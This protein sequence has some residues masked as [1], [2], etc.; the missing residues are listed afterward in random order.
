MRDMPPPRVRPLLD[1]ERALL[2]HM[3]NV[4]VPDVATLW[5]QAEVASAAADPPLAWNVYL[6]VPRDAPQFHGLDDST[7][8][9][10]GTT[11]RLVSRATSADIEHPQAADVT[12]WT[13]QGYL[14][15]IRVSWFEE[16]PTGL[17]SVDELTAAK[18]VSA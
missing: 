15:E 9:V 4:A 10:R 7:V 17:P 18:V 12:L 16:Q 11:G 5:K 2:A 6:W 3:L 14:A 8:G 1:D 13:D